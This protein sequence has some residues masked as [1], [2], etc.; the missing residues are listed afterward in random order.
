[1]NEK[2][3]IVS[4]HAPVLMLNEMNRKICPSESKLL[5]TRIHDSFF[6]FFQQGN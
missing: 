4:F 5:G 1:M 2:R 6:S 3:T